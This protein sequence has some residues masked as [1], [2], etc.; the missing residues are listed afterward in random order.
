MVNNDADMFAIGQ[1]CCF[2][3]CQQ[4]DFLPF[5]CPGCTLT[6]CAEHRTCTAHNCTK[7]VVDDSSAV[8][9]CPLCAKAIKVDHGVDPNQAFEAYVYELLFRLSILSY[10]NA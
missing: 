4:L 9:V 3:S 5:T 6:F 2:E 10:F 8:I 7:P 1:H